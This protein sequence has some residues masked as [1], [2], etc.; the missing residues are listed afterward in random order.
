M[1]AERKTVFAVAA[2]VALG[3][4]VR[5]AHFVRDDPIWHDEAAAILNVIHKS[6]SELW[7]PRLVNATE[8]PLFLTIV[9]ASADFWGD[10]T[11]ALRLPSF[12]AGCLAF[13]LAVWWV[14]PLLSGAGWIAFAFMAALSDRLLFHACEAKT[15]SFDFLIA[16]LFLKLMLWDDPAITD[17]TVSWRIRRRQ[18]LAAA[19]LS[20]L[21]FLSYP[22]VFMLASFGIIQLGLAVGPWSKDSPRDR[23]EILRSIPVFAGFALLSAGCA[24]TLVFGT[25]RAIQTAAV[26][27]CWSIEFPNY[28]RPWTLPLQLLGKTLDTFRYAQTPVGQLLGAFTIVGG[29]AYAR[30][31]HGRLVAWFSLLFA[32]NAAAWIACRYPL[33]HYRVIV[34]LL[35][36]IFLFAAHGLAAAVKRLDTRPALSAALV[37]TLASITVGQTVY[38]FAIPWPRL[39]ST[40]ASRFVLENRGPSEPVV[41]GAW[42]QEYYLRR[43]GPH[44]RL[45]PPSIDDTDTDSFWFL[46]NTRDFGPEFLPAY[47]ASGNWTITSRTQFKHYVVLRFQRRQVEGRLTSRGA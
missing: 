16:V 47:V 24:L 22:L 36:L 6:Y 5:G 35:P 19:A 27:S 20:A 45:Q 39:D 46:G 23:A 10:E 14:R 4:A 13:V 2:L 25:L 1:I 33:G 30:Q 32:M 34:Y 21:V 31:G 7:G 28:G 42:E 12:L 29:I 3:L 38:R 41:P 37:M 26:V 44:L 15:Y 40:D 17:T 43:L 11:W 8:P 9:K 18:C